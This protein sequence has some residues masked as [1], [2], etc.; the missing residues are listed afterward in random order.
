MGFPDG[1][2]IDVK[3]WV[4]FRRIVPGWLHFGFRFLLSR[5]SRIVARSIWP[6]TGYHLPPSSEIANKRSCSRRAN[7]W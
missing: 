6:V 2:A 4:I 1:R 7:A 5:R 3:G